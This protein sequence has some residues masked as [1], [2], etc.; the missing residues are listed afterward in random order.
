MESGDHLSSFTAE[1]QISKAEAIIEPTA[2]SVRCL[3][4]RLPVSTCKYLFTCESGG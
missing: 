3:F 1:V 4:T 2:A